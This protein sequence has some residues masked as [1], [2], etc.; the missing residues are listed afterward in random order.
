[1]A[2]DLKIDNILKTE[3]ISIMWLKMELRGVGEARSG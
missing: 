2:E 1:M 3:E